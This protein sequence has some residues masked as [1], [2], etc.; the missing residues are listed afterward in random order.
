MSSLISQFSIYS[1]KSS[2]VGGCSS[3]ISPAGLSL[4]GSQGV[5]DLVK[6]S[7][8]KKRIELSGERL[9]FFGWN[10]VVRRQ[11]PVI[12]AATAADDGGHHDGF[13]F[14]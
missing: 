12:K 1:S 5:V 13:V 11:I 14:F 2:N 7:P 10:E 9:R 4:R 6:V 3:R 8:E